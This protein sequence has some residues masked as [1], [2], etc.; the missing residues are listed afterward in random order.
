MCVDN[1]CCRGP[2]IYEVENLNNIYLFFMDRKYNLSFFY[3]IL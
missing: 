3:I 2:K 1:K